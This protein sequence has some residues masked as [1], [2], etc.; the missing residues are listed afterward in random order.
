VGKSDV[1]VTVV[2][3]KHQYDG[4]GVRSVRY[5]ATSQKEEWYDALHFGPESSRYQILGNGEY[6]LA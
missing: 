6:A 3:A 2:V 4:F 5:D 1:V